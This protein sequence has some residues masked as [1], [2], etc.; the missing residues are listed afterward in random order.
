MNTTTSK[1][2][3]YPGSFDPITNG[4]ENVIERSLDLFEK[5][6]VAVAKISSHDKQSL[7]SSEE[8]TEIIRELFLGQ[9]RVQVISFDGL[10]VDLAKELQTPVIIRGLRAVSDFEYEFQMAQMNR[11]L[12]NEVETIFLAPDQQYSFLSSTLV[13]EVATLGGDVSDFVSPLVL[14]KM[15]ERL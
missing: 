6:F 8:R 5:V 4:H 10:L 7:F 1:S 14:K 11:Q 12:Q 13:R 2:V 3:I 15:L 9:E